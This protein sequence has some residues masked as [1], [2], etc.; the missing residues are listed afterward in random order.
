MSEAYADYVEARYQGEVFG[1]A[2]FGAMAD[3]C[4]DPGNSRKLRALE[5]LERET[6]ELL[7]PEV[8]ALG[9]AIEPDAE[10]LEQGRTVGAAMGQAPW[11][12]ILGGM[13]GELVNFIDDFRRSESL[14]PPGK[15]ALLRQ[16]TA[17]EQALLDFVD[18]ELAKEGGDSLAPVRTLLRGPLKH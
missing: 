18:L 2:V 13:R 9:R 16:V 7:E 3:A 14:A 8:A 5:Q 11:S 12:D 15:E 10:K 6:K 17:H 1:E 4:V